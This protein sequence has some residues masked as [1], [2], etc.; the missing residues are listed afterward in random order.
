MYIK[1]I[2]RLPVNRLEI[3]HYTAQLNIN[4]IK[5]INHQKIIHFRNVFDLFVLV[6]NYPTFHH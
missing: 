5:I 6:T 4:K 3:S 1:I 2:L